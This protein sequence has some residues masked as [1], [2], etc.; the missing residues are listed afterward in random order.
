MKLFFSF[1]VLLF[2][3][4]NFAFIS[5]LLMFVLCITFLFLFCHFVG[6]RVFLTNKL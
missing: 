6:Q 5:L 3:V 2:L 4:F 1:C